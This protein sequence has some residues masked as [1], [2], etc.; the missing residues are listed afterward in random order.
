MTSSRLYHLKECIVGDLLALRLALSMSKGGI[1]GELFSERLNKWS[2][3]H[4][5]LKE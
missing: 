4:L 5:E 1:W 3:R 2:T